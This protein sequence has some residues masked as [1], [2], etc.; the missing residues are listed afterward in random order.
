MEFTFV[1]VLEC[2][3]SL[4]YIVWHIR[5]GHFEIAFIPRQ[6]HHEITVFMLDL[7]FSLGSFSF[8]VVVAFYF[9]GLPL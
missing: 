8:I 9:S 5:V 4:R 6:G 3:A 2:V 1:H 7:M